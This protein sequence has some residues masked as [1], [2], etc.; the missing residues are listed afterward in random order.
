MTANQVDALLDALRSVPENELNAAPTAPELA[1]L[2]GMGIHRVR[3]RL[4]ALKAAGRVKV[5]PVR[6]IRLD[7]QAATVPGYRIAS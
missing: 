3:K 4:T 6:R 5:V 2:L 7:D 1:Q